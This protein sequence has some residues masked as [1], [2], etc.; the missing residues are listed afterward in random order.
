MVEAG[1]RVDVEHLQCQTGWV[2]ERVERFCAYH[3]ETGKSFGRL[4]SATALR[5]LRVGLVVVGIRVIKVWD[6]L[7]L[8]VHVVGM[9]VQGC[10]KDFRVV[11]NGVRVGVWGYVGVHVLV[12]GDVHCD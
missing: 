10:G 6:L 8:G 3:G 11:G 2:S 5:V 7:V 12:V 1:A 9:G 4:S